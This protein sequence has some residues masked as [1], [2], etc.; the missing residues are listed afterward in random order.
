MLRWPRTFDLPQS[1]LRWS[2]APDSERLRRPNSY[3][4][5]ASRDR[6]M[7][8]EVGEV[9]LELLRDGRYAKAVAR[10]VCRGS[11]IRGSVVQL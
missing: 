5:D 9:F 6:Q 10:I 3:L 8:P 1:W 2:N 7:R 4:P 11:R